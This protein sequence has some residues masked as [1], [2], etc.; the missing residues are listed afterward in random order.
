[1]NEEKQICERCIYDSSISRIT[2]DDE[3]ICNYCRQIEDLQVE[4][5]T[6]EEKGIKTFELILEKIKKSGKGKKYDCVIGVSGGTDS[7]YML[8]K[9]IDW[10]LRPLAVH[11]DN[12]WNAAVATMNIEK[13]TSATNIDLYTYVVNNKEHDD[14][15]KA[16]LYASVPEFD[17]DTDIAYIQ[18]LRM[19]AAKF[20]VKYIFEGHSYHEEGLT[21]V[22]SNY[23][24]GGYVSSI[25]NNHGSIKRKSFPNMTFYQFL[26]WTIIY[27]QEFIRPFWYIEYTKEKA[28]QELI[29]RTG[30]IYYG[31]HH[32]ENRASSFAHLSWL[33]KKFGIDYRNLTLSAKV[34]NGKLS[35]QS[36]LAEYSI[37]AK[38]DDNLIYYVK[39]RLG[40]S[41]A[42]YD[43]IFSKPNKS[44][45]DYKTYKKRFE[46]LRP[47]F[48]ILAKNKRVP[49]SFYLKYC[50]PLSDE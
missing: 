5:G 41:D 17:A 31:G 4:Y 16:F 6:G 15:K 27:K 3:G 12:T 45:K 11:Y 20:G 24:D 26:K 50:F 13:V 43:E 21:P 47:L 10:G 49:M 40:I 28:R 37:P 48:Y 22:G 32:L 23:L 14:I 30:W 36:A 25:H 33:P 8:L 35:R 18:V 34:R 29:D 38:E 19:V 44:W 7:S 2:F 1:M 46:A 39:K 42:E 9:A